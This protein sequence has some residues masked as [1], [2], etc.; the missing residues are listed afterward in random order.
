MNGNGGHKRHDEE[1]SIPE[2][3]QP[4]VCRGFCGACYH[5]QLRLST[6]GARDLVHY[7]W[8]LN[9]FASRAVELNNRHVGPQA[10]S[11][12]VTH[13]NHRRRAA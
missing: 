2:C 13:I 8:R 7:K 11:A 6:L 1:C 5:W 4:A 12:E 9:R 3:G 10:K